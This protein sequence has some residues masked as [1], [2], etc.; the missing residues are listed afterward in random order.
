MPRF[1]Q[2]VGMTIS[3]YMEFQTWPPPLRTRELMNYGRQ[4]IKFSDKAE[5]HGLGEDTIYIGEWLEHKNKPHGR[6]IQI[7]LESTRTG[8]SWD[9]IK[10][11]YFD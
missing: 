7:Q 10:I 2:R 5:E 6:G 11:L 9:V 8:V 3:Q 4:Y 1:E